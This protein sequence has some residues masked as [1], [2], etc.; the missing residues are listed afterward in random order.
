MQ[1]DT[2][3]YSMIWIT[4]DDTI[5][6]AAAADICSS[7]R[8]QYTSEDTKIFVLYVKLN[9]EYNLILKFWFKLFFIIS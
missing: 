9:I 5:F 4:N 3:Y 8:L 7:G 1:N 2:Y 6:P